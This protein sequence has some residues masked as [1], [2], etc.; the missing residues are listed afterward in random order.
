MSSSS[1]DEDD[2]IDGGAGADTLTL[3]ASTNAYASVTDATTETLAVSNIE[4]LALTAGAD[5]DAIDFDLFAT[6]TDFTKVAVT[7]TADAANITLTDIQTDH[8][9][10]RNTNDG[11]NAETL[12]ALTY[13]KKDS[14][15]TA[16]ALTLDI[17]NRDIN[18][19][20]TISTITAAGI[21]TLTL[22]TTGGTD[23]DMT[24]STLT[25]TAA[26]T[27]NITGD[28]DLTISSTLATT[29]ETI[30]A[31]TSTGDLTLTFGVSNA[32]VTGGS[33][34]DTFNFAETLTEEDTIDGGA[35]TDT[36]TV[37]G[38]NTASTAL[39]LDLNLTNIERFTFSEDESS[40]DSITFD[41]NGDYI[42][43]IT[44]GADESSDDTINFED[45]GS[46]NI[47]IYYDGE[48][49]SAD[50]D[51]TTFDRSTDTA[52]DTADIFLTYGSV[53]TITL[54]DEETITLDTTASATEQAIT[55]V[56]LDASDATSVT[57]TNDDAW[58]D[59][60]I[61]SLTANSI[62]TGATIDFT[63]M[64]QSIGNAAD[65]VDVAGSDGAANTVG[66]H[67]F[68]E[69]ASTA[70]F[71]AVATG[72]YTIKLGDNRT[73][74]D[75]ETVIDLGSS[76]TG[77]DTV[78][79]VNGATDAT[80]D[81]GVVLINNF[82]DAAGAIVNNRSLLDLSAFGIQ[83]TSDLTITS[84]ASEDNASISI[85]TAADSDDFAGSI[86]V[87][88]VASTDWATSDFVFEA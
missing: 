39:D 23:G 35:G 4:T 13:D 56:D 20:F 36:V 47:D 71:T 31:G 52:S 79:F 26:E 70:G 57:I 42:S 65:N 19:D 28:A 50:G 27:I 17:T 77:A 41:F 75:H 1:L 11:T 15:G 74:T 46:G 62:K 9:T 59:G 53:G 3:T 76:N 85:I 72:K 29:V 55:I 2:T 18:E 32:T 60:D 51:T 40:D 54:N 37:G 12:N 34:A 83:S 67:T 24:I 80:N 44:I 68:A 33:G 73:Q 82:N 30:S 38:I 58:D 45:L 6:P 16:D 84:A 63:G 81:L 5:G 69:A 86:T 8:V 66:A 48:T 43:R 7:S 21:E 14:T 25:A 49:G 22:N 88:G 87:L 78:Q 10:V 61:F 64:I